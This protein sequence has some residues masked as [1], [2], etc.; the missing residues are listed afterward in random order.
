MDEI[1]VVGNGIILEK[2]FYSILLVKKGVFVENL[3]T[4]VK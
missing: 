2:G 3:K 4:F 1:V